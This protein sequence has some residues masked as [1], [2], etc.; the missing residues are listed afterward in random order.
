MRGRK[1]R[2][3]IRNREA[4]GRSGG[5]CSVADI[6]SGGVRVSSTANKKATTL[7]KPRARETLFDTGTSSKTSLVLAR[8]KNP[9]RRWPTQSN[10]SASSNDK[11]GRQWCADRPLLQQLSS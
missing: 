8:K 4:R 9:S 11:G 2:P 5:T 10:L 6:R 3:P 7:A 1:A